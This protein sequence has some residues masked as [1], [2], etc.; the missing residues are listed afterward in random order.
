M[1]LTIE[2]VF[3]GYGNGDVLKG[4]SC[5]ADYGDV[6]CLLGPNGCG[7]TTLFRMM[8]GTLPVTDGKIA[9]DTCV[10]GASAWLSLY[11]I[12]LSKN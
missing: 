8:L 2:N 12:K 4:I 10:S 6:L 3:G 5:N 9:I 7:K 1:L 11:S